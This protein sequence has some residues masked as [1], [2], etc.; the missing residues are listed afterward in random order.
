MLDNEAVADE[1][2]IELDEA[3]ERAKSDEAVKADASP[4]ESYIDDEE[5]AV[6]NVW[7]IQS[8]EDA[9]WAL[10]RIGDLEQEVAEN[11][12]VF[13]KALL[14]LKLRQAQLSKRA[15]SGIAFFTF[16]L[17]A[18]AEAHRAELIKGKKKSRALLHGSLGWRKTGGGLEVTDK[19]ALLVWARA[20]P[21]ESE[22]LRITEA[23]AIAN[24][25]KHFKE[26]GEVPPGTEPK[27][28]VD[29]FTL[30]TESK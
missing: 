29:V 25:Q 26:T 20:Q 23:P 27:P 21:V 8:L 7:T 28:E 13:D 5:P 24:L 2:Q 30:K 14:R 1:R 19:E 10:K 18:Y 17:Q 3:I 12:K 16:K 11:Q 6:S 4:P 9:D 22:L 15:N